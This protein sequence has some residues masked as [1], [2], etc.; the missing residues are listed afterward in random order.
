MGPGGAMGV[1]EITLGVSVDGNAVIV[2]VGMSVLVTVGMGVGV[3]TAWV[4]DG[5]E[6]IVERLPSTDWTDWVQ[7]LRIRVTNKSNIL[8]F[9]GTPL[10]D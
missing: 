7:L 4:T 9:I 3:L 5:L 10:A 6:V 8:R 2:T 1:V